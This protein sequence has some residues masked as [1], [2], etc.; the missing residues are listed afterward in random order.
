MTSKSTVR[1]QSSSR[2]VFSAGSARVPGV[3]HSGF[4][5]MP[6]CCSRGSGGLA[7]VGGGASFGSR[8]LYG[9][10]GSKRISLGGGS[11]ALGGGYGGRDG[12]SLGFGGG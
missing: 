6:V 11:C 8:S 10:A 12:S 3:G 5:S 4:S 9:M 1:S 7:G 2:R